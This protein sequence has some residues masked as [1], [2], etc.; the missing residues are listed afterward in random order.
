MTN[1]QQ[2]EEQ[3]PVKPK[4]KLWSVVK[5]IL[6]AGIG[7]QSNK[8]REKDFQEGSPLAFIIGG[9]VFNL[10]FIV[11]VETIVCVVLSKN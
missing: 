9:F 11:T 7:V 2:A 4:V 5:S 6:A 1:S 10:L 3:S 8:N